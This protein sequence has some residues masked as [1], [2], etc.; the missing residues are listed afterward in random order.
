MI[1]LTIDE[2][3]IPTTKFQSPEGANEQIKSLKKH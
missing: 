3:E 1:T 2:N